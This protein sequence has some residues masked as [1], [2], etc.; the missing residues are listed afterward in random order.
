MRV[1]KLSAR[2]AAMASFVSAGESIADI[3]ADHGYLP[4]YL[5]R[6]GISPFAVLTDVQEGPLEKTRLSVEKALG[7]NGAGLASGQDKNQGLSLYAL[8]TRLGDGLS[9]LEKAEVDVIVIA[10]MGGETIISILAADPEKTKSFRKYILQPRTKT[11]LLKEWL[12]DAGFI[13]TSETKAD[14]KGRLCDIIVCIS[15]LP[16]EDIND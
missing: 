14:E 16:H 15:C 9:V 5:M 8:A 13:I 2:L 1:K 6:E 3:G 12:S 4:L 11:D 7:Q 10:G